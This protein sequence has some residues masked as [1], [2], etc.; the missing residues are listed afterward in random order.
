MKKEQRYVLS[1]KGKQILRQAKKKYSKSEKG[2]QAHKRNNDK[3]SNTFGRDGCKRGCSGMLK[4]DYELTEQELMRR[5]VKRKQH[6]YK[7]KITNPH[8]VLVLYDGSLDNLSTQEYKRMQHAEYMRQKR[9]A[10]FGRTG[11]KKPS[12]HFLFDF[13]LE[14]MLKDNVYVGDGK[15]KKHITKW[16]DGEIRHWTVNDGI[17]KM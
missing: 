10:I 6:K 15:Y 17:W 13:D 7:T 12:E 2:K 3:Y 1:V 8:G 11:R 4:R 9:C 14:Q 5:N 16:W